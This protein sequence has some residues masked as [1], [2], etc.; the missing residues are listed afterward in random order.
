M[1]CSLKGKMRS[2]DILDNVQATLPVWPFN[3]I[4]LKHGQASKVNM[5]LEYMIIEVDNVM[6]SL[7][8]R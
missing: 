2:G 8:Y 5:E 1:E 7:P 6:S 4:L 3:L